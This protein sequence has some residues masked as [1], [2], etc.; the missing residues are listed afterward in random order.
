VYTEGY[1]QPQRIRTVNIYA[2]LGFDKRVSDQRLLE[3]IREESW[4]QQMAHQ[5]IAMEL[6]QLQEYMDD[7]EAQRITMLGEIKRIGAH[8]QRLLAS[9]V[10][11]HDQR[12]LLALRSQIRSIR[13]KL[14]HSFRQFHQRIYRRYMPTGE[15]L[16]A[17]L[18]SP[19]DQLRHR[20]E[21]VIRPDVQKVLA[22]T[23]DLVR[24]F[25]D[26]KNKEKD[27]AKA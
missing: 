8:R 10:G 21:S 6:S 2:L 4:F 5:R 19:R 7:F 22:F 18:R 20:F 3:I 9:N 27:N 11:G 14:E 15:D 1:Y 25:M 16:E 23:G 13:Q 17:S 24:K 12:Q 26:P